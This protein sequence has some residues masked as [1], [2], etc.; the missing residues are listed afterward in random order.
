[1]TNGPLAGVRILDAAT[2]LAAP[3]CGVILAD[4]G[5]E[6]IKVEQ[7]GVGD[8][9]RKFGT[10]TECGDSL[11]WLSEARNKKFVTLDLR[12]QRGAQMFRQLAA[13]SDVVLENFR[14]G[15]MEKWGLGLE[16]LREVNPKLVMLRISAYGQDGPYR[17]KP[18]FARIAHAFSG[19]S[20]LAGES[21]R[22]P[23]V[24][25]STSIGDYVS[26]MWGA[27]G[28]LLALRSVEQG[29]AGQAVD[30]GLYEGVFRLLDELV[31]AY[32]KFGVVRERMGADVL[33]VVPHGHWKCGDD[34]WIAIACSSE[35][36]FERLAAVMGRPDLMTS[37]EFRTNEARVKNRDAMNAIV[38]AWASSLRRED[39]LAACDRGE[40]AC[41]PVLNVAEICE[42]EHYLSRG[43]F[44]PVDN[45][46]VS[47][48]VLPTQPLRLS[49]TPAEFQ[50]VGGALGQDTDEVYTQLLGLSASEI[51]G[52]RSDGVI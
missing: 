1:L 40:V 36:M 13:G 3:F 12:K 42:D 25:G 45:P 21:G 8:P 4:F 44:E 37:P 27:I 47:D 35:K 24:P 31:P 2:F 28:V 34:K 18:G 23:V 46:R 5:A 30:I 38:A 41:G 9:L 10:T 22:Q 17:S 15:T 48:L 14:P 49:E 26:G 33:F 43:N 20:Y 32:R 11:V 50:H 16:A 29:G 7:P 6:V 19:L 39:V 52:L 51:A